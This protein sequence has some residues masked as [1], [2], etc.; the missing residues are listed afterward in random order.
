M[1]TGTTTV[2]TSLL[3]SLRREWLLGAAIATT[4][5]F[6]MFGK[7]WLSDLSNPLWFALMLIWLFA[8]ILSSAFAV[9]H[10]AEVLAARLGEPL[11]TLVLTLS[12][13]GIEVMMISAVMLTGEGKPELARD[14]MLGVTMIVMNGMIG[15]SL[16]MGGLR[17]REQDYNLQGANSFLSLIV[18]LTVLGLVLPNF[19]SASP[20]PTFSVLQSIF[21]AVMSIAIYILFLIIQNRRHKEYFVRPALASGEYAGAAHGDHESP[22]S[23]AYHA[24]LLVLYLLAI[25]VLAEE[26]AVPIDHG[27]EV[28]H[29]PVALGGFLVAALVLS[30]ESLSAT[31]AALANDLQRSINILLGSVLA[32]IGLTIPAVLTIGLVT[33]KTVILGLDSANSLLLILTLFVSTLTFARNRTN[34]LMGAVHL[35]LFLAYVMLIF[36][37]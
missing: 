20:G 10:H 8:V 27:I 22:N 29:A 14:A 4:A 15:I 24:V 28:L 36:E 3:S 7:Q 13:I 18:P 6:L 21:L 2:K 33:G 37:H 9:V 23:S 26:I 30:P 11:G 1:N 35:L 5:L 19:T 31:R 17:H 12:V 16:L 34:V 25:V 32:S